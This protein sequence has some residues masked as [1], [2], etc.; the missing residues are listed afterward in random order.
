MS[1]LITQAQIS[2]CLY[3]VLPQK[4]K[5]R[6]AIHEYKKYEKLNKE[7]LEKKYKEI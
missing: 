4:L 3:D 7:V 1:P 5:T 2:D 6:I